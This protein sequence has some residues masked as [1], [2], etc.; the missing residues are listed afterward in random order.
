MTVTIVTFVTVMG[1]WQVSWLAHA[2][3]VVVPGAEYALDMGSV[4]R[5][6]V[7]S[8]PTSEHLLEHTPF[9][10]FSFPPIAPLAFEWR[11]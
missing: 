10:H 4:F 5:R 2:W 6:P 3:S 8:L 1:F 7:L 11:F 9:L